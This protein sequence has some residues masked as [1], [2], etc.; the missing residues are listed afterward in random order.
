MLTRKRLPTVSSS[1]GAKE[2]LMY[3]NYI[4]ARRANAPVS[5]LPKSP[6]SLHT[7]PSL[8]THQRPPTNRLL[9]QLIPEKDYHRLKL[10]KGGDPEAVVLH[11]GRCPDRLEL[12]QDLGGVALRVECEGGKGRGWDLLLLLAG[13]GGMVVRRVGGGRRGGCD[14]EGGRGGREERGRCSASCSCTRGRSVCHDL[15]TAS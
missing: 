5:L 1:E 4:V 10:V 7:S 8:K 11:D 12:H 3:R 14:W 9:P 15:L 6:A 13:G 2:L